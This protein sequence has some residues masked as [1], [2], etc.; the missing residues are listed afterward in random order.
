MTI[1]DIIKQAEGLR[2]TAYIDVDG[3]LTIGYGHTGPDVHVGQTITIEEAGRLLAGDIDEAREQ[4]RKLCPGLTGNRL[5]AI[6]D[7]VFNE[8][9]GRLEKSTLRKQ[10]LCMAFENVPAELRRWVYG[11]GVRLEGLVARRE[12]EIRLWNSP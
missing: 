9:S 12:A 7:F 4:T 5:D 10:I 11:N 2:L 3:V 6:T 8:G 1:Q